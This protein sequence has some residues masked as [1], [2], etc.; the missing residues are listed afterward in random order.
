MFATDY[1]L[2]TTKLVV[3][4]SEK[5]MQSPATQQ[6]RA[7]AGL[8]NSAEF[9][10]SSASLPLADRHIFGDAT[11]Q[12]A[13]RFSESLG[14]VSAL[15]DTCKFIFELAFNSKN[16]FMAKAFKFQ[17]GKDRGICLSPA[18]TTSVEADSL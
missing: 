14:P 9:D 12:A 4:E 5:E 7:I 16:K 2:G 13:L 17:N 15:R 10:Q 18:E 11:D 6:V 8:C 3:G 1:S